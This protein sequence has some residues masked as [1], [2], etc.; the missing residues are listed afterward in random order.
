MLLEKVTRHVS[1]IETK[2]QALEAC[3]DLHVLGPKKVNPFF[4]PNII[5]NVHVKHMHVSKSNCYSLLLVLLFFV[6]MNPFGSCSY[7]NKLN[8][9]A[10][11]HLIKGSSRTPSYVLHNFQG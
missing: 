9:C 1:S 8:L 10:C 6:Y 11:Q 5:C 2:V 7:V 4:P 3:C